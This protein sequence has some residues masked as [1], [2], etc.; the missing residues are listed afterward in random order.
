M[1]CITY[2]YTII[3]LFQPSQANEQRVAGEILTIPPSQL[4][5]CSRFY[6]DTFPDRR[7]AERALRAGA[8]RER[9]PCWDRRLHLTQ[10]LLSMIGV[11][12]AEYYSKIVGGYRVY[13]KELCRSVAK[14]KRLDCY[15][16]A[17]SM[18]VS[19]NS[20]L[21]RRLVPATKRDC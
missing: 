13:H 14:P 19:C 8:S 7:C 6:V 11:S 16:P 12:A 10:Y 3:A 5:I 15:S 17:Q 1:S 4:S 20:Q 2:T 21:H 18:L 9:P